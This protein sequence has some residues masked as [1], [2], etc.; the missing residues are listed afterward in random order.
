MLF[1]F[2]SL[3]R[4]W[5]E[6]STQSVSRFGEGL[7]RFPDGTL[8][9]PSYILPTHAL[10]FVK[11]LT[12][13]ESLFGDGIARMATNGTVFVRAPFTKKNRK[14]V[15]RPPDSQGLDAYDI[16]LQTFRLV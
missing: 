7:S 1:T 4:H 13:K 12:A 14:G 10:D 9:V 6:C 15:S 3:L 11:H 5:K 16:L 2:F 8:C